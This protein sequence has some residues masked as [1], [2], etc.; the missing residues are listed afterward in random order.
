MVLTIAAVAAHKG[1]DPL[2]I[3]VEVDG[4]DYRLPLATIESARL[5]PVDG[6]GGQLLAQG[7]PEEISADPRVIDAYLGAR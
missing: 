5:V 7:T 6:D 2:R 3:E 1:I 4:K